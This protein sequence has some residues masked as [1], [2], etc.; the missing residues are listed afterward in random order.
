MAQCLE[1]VH[2][3]RAQAVP[4][5][6]AFCLARHSL[7]LS[8]EAFLG[9]ES[10]KGS[11][12]PYGEGKALELASLRKQFADAGVFGSMCGKDESTCASGS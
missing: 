2:T 7:R 10:I 9:Q 12:E 6:R 11:R 3:G 8:A 1:A 4:W 5:H